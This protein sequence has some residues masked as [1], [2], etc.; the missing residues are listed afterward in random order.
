MPGPIQCVTVAAVDVDAGVAAYR[1]YLDYRLG[2]DGRVSAGLAEQWGATG[3]VGRRYVV[4]HPQHVEDRYLRIVEIDPVAEYR[5]F[6]TLGWNAIEIIV[7]DTDVMADRLRQ[8]PFQIVGEPH[9]LSFS[10]AIRAMQAI[11]PAGEV[12]YLTMLKRPVEAFDLPSVRGEVGAPFIVISGGDLA[13][14]KKHYVG[15]FGLPEAPEM[16]G[17]ISVLSNAYR[18]PEDTGHRIAALPLGDANYIELDQYPDAAVA[19]PCTEG[20]LPPGQSLVTFEVADLDQIA[21]VWR[22]P[23]RCLDEPPYAG[24]KAGTTVG[25]AGEWIEIVSQR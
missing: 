4:M 12:I 3:M 24:R 6:R 14:L 9:D 8:S 16:V 10:D 21:A 7:R 17:R 22:S 25:P 19:R 18:M 11:G 23:P 5:P 2:F 20:H 1:D 13:A 15:A